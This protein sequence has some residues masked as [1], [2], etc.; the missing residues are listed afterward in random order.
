MGRGAMAEHRCT[1]RKRVGKALRAQASDRYSFALPPHRRPGI[2]D[3]SINAGGTRRLPIMP[4]MAD[5]VRH[6]NQGDR[7]AARAACEQILAS[8]SK[9]NDARLLLAILLI[10]DGDAGRGLS[11]LE[12]IVASAPNNARA[13]HALGKAL[14][15]LGRSGEAVTHLEQVI[16]QQPLNIDAYLDLGGIHLRCQQTP[17][18]ERV[19]RQALAAAPQH[20]AVLSNLG[21][22]LAANGNAAEGIG[23]LRRAVT[24]SPQTAAARY[25]LAIA[26]KNGGELEQAVAEYRAAVALKPDYVD[27]WHNLGNALLD[28][29]RVDEAA[30]AYESATRVRRRPGAA[31]TGDGFAKLNPGKLRHDIEQLH[32]L[33]DH[34]RL[35][36]DARKVIVDYEAA[37]ALLPANMSGPGANLLPAELR[38]RLASSYNRLLYRPPAEREPGGA[39]NRGLDAAAIEADYRRHGP[40]ITFIDDFLSPAALASL[41]RFCL[42]ATVWYESRYAN[43]Y[44]G[45][46][47]DDGFCCP[48]LLQIAEEL[49]R[50]LPGIFQQHTLRKLWGFKYDSRL[51]GI[52]MHAD[53]AAVNVNFWVTPDDANLDPDGGGLIVWDKEAPLDWDFATYNN[54]QAALRRFLTQSQARPVPVP[55][56]QNRVVIFNSDLIHETAPLKFRD[57]YENRRVNI[58]MLYGK[59]GG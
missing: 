8:G 42:E 26:L 15:R 54:D 33:I 6:Y 39:V 53:F 14:A 23:L 45:A 9:D 3:P 11:L 59:R 19:L 50:A 56:R 1:L 32:H 36:A 18:A 40:G 47:F 16:A 2:V 24:A 17:A 55:H 43:G 22:L 51:S 12:L 28:L 4:T 58:T 20:P 57:G 41:R 31:P 10:E 34:G 5:A 30:A 52:P 29:G 44:L 35:G 21:G 37:L 46:F 7:A 25:N 49:R 48:L 38:Q 27:G 13:R